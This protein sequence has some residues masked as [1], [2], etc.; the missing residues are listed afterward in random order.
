MNWV[1]NWTGHELQLLE[2]FENQVVIWIK[3]NKL[4]P[5]EEIFA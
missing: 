5:Y 2:D 3:L 1:R 4:G